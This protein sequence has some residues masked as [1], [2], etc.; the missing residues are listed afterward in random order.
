MRVH[1]KLTVL[2]VVSLVAAWILGSCSE[3]PTDVPVP[4]RR[5]GV[6]IS[7]GP[8]RDSVNIFIATFNWNAADE[9]GQVVRFLFAIDDTT[10][11]IETVDY[12]ATLLFTATEIAGAD[13]VRIGL[14]ESFRVRYRFRDMHTFYLKAIDDDGDFSPISAL[15]F[16]AETVAPETG[17]LNPSPSGTALV[18]HT[19]TVTW[20]GVDIDGTEDPVAYS[21]RLVQSIAGDPESL[22]YDPATPGDPWSPFEP[23]TSVRFEDLEVPQNYIFGV[24]A[25][26]QAGAIE[27]HLRDST[28]PSWTAGNTNILYVRALEDGGIPRLCVSSSV[29]TTCFP[30][31]DSARKTFQIPAN[32]NV[33]FTWTADATPYGGTIAG[34]SYGLDLDDPQNLN[35]PGWQPESA[36][37]TRAVIRY[38]LPEGSNRQD[39]FLYVRARDD[40][41]T[42]IIAD[43]NLVV[44][45]LS[46]NRDVALRGRLRARPPGPR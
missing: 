23:R 19:F 30:T 41:G 24:V 4:N 8:I 32:S 31:A 26:D 18:G 35:D 43:V 7:A 12:E 11:W 17:I 16:N 34:Y 3:S 27:P 21:Y 14:G 40:I 36:N 45:P 39:R 10:E 1:W 25:M 46:Q 6:A 29:K 28:V 20:E 37:L 42:V 22:L 44:I 2:G 5:P 15:S 13:S 33:T 38:D 9:D